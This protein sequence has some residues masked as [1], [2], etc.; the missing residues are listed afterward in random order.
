MDE[1]AY[2]EYRDE[3]A[4]WLKRGRANLLR[5]LLAKHLPRGNQLELLELGAGVGQNLPVLSGFGTVN[6]AEISPIGQSAIRAQGTARHL[7]TDPLPFALERKYDVICALDVI[8]HIGD[9]R[10]AL[11]WVGEHLRHRGV[12]IATVPAYGWLF[13]DHDR[14]LHHFRRYTRASFCRALPEELSVREAAYFNHLLFPLAVAARGLW[15]LGRMVTGAQ[16]GKQ[17]SPRWGGAQTVLARVLD[18]EVELIL[19]G[20][21]PAWGLSVYCVAY[22]R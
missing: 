4:D 9:D 7:Y 15:S 20:Y 14:S 2:L 1:R 3:A 22:R 5:G 16:P 18:L 19:R 13:S 8:E 10:A 11:R 12:F 21:E 6:A 17:R